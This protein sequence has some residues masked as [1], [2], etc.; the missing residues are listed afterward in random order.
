MA[1][2]PTNPFP[3]KTY[4]RRDHSRSRNKVSLEDA[5]ASDANILMAQYRR[6]GTLP[7]VNAARPLYGNFTGPTDLA[8][9]I[10]FV[11]AARERFEQLPASVRTS[12]DNDPVEFLRMFDDPDERVVLEEA[13][14]LISDEPDTFFQN[15]ESSPPPQTEDEA[16]AEDPVTS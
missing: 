4:P 9:Q 13:G 11:E 15:S 12:C 5:R 3:A 6:N 2:R 1:A 7:R 14:L 8:Q 16:P 10:E